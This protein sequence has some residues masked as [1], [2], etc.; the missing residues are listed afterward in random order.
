MVDQVKPGE[1]LEHS[2]EQS[3]AKALFYKATFNDYR[4]LLL[5]IY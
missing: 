4:K 3:A 1:L 2:T 5:I